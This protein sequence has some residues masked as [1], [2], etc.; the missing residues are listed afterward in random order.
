[1]Q[2]F[3]LGGVSAWVYCYITHT[4]N[5]KRNKICTEEIEETH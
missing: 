2:I 5:L 4:F 1:M 3:H